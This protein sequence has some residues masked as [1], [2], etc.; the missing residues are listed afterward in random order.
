MCLC[1][2]VRAYMCIC[3]S[4]EHHGMCVEVSFHS[5]VDSFLP[6]CDFRLLNLGPELQQS[7]TRP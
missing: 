7:F 5:G 1:I 4:T 6:P 3:V 2:R